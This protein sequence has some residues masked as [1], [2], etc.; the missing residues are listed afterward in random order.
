MQDKMNSA[1]V[2]PK[3]GKEYTGKPA[4]SRLDN[5]TLICPD[6]GIME[7]LASLGIAHDEQQ[8]IL[9][10]IHSHTKV[11]DDGGKK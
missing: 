8:Q 2:C 11:F 5:A 9:E 4:L 10:T 6:C 1:T 7:A 3:C